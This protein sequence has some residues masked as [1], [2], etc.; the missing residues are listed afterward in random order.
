MKQPQDKQS[1]RN[2]IVRGF[3]GITEVAVHMIACVAIGVFL[4]WGLDRLLGT[5]PWLLLACSLL[6]AAAAI[7]AIFTYG[8]RMK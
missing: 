8:K 4:G 1:S 5:A 2:D 7:R 3:A 6:G